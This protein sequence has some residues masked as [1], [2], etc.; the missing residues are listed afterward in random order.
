MKATFE[1]GAYYTMARVAA[2]PKGRRHLRLNVTSQAEADARVVVIEDALQRLER[3][4]QGDLR[5]TTALR[6]AEASAEEIDALATFARE[7][8]ARGAYQRASSAMLT[9]EQFGEQWTGGQLAETWRGQVR[10]LKRARAVALALR[11]H[12]YPVIGKLPLS[13]VT[14]EDAEAVAR[15]IT[16]PRLRSKKGILEYCR[17][18]FNLAVYPAKLIRHNPIPKELLAIDDDARNFAWLRTAE[19]RQLLRCRRV[20]LERRVCWGLMIFEG[21][22]PEDATELPLSAVD[23]KTGLITLKKHKTVRYHGERLWVLQPD[24]TRGLRAFLRLQPSD[25]GLFW[26]IDRAGAA[27]QLRRDLRTAGITRVELHETTST[28]RA[29]RAHDLRATFVTLA[30]AADWPAS[31]RRERT[32][33]LNARTEQVYERQARVAADLGMGWPGSFDTLIPELAAA[34]GLGQADEGAAY[35]GEPVACTQEALPGAK[36]ASRKFGPQVEANKSDAE[37]AGFTGKSEGQ[38]TPSKTLRTGCV[39]GP[40]RVSGTP[41]VS[42]LRPSRLLTRRAA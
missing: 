3:A 31:R 19:V 20:P 26:Q 29:M 39:Q 11:K 25:G 16:T 37:T 18:L 30:I 17:R 34:R 1:H 15:G 8:L 14:V 24:V 5:E 7:K 13:A 42:D 27:A 10:P 4:G 9:V 12:L 32:G 40:R 21:L 23:L 28:R 33:H 38:G 22:R 2:G 6:L 35:R 36:R 41:R